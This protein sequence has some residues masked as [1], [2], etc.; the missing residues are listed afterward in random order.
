MSIWA[1]LEKD[2]DDA[3]KFIEGAFVG[4]FKSE[5]VTVKAEA[6]KVLP[7]LTSD[8]A[9]AAATGK[10]SSLGPVLGALFTQTATELEASA[11]VTG[12]QSLG[13]TVTAVLASEPSVAA[14]I[15]PATPAAEPTPTPAT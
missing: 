8:I 14:M 9:T 13:T 4:L 6:E 2:I 12:I 10:L 7:T 3:G 11:V 1:D 15:A 5:V